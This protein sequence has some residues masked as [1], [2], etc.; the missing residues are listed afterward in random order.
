MT[1]GSCRPMLSSPTSKSPVNSDEGNSTDDSGI[2]SISDHQQKQQQQQQQ[3]QQQ[4][5]Q[6]Q[7]QLKS[8]K[9]RNIWKRELVISQPLVSKAGNNSKSVASVKD[10][11][12]AIETKFGAKISSST[13]AAAASTKNVPVY[14]HVTKKKS[15]V[16]GGGACGPGSKSAGLKRQEEHHHR[17]KCASLKRQQQQGEHANLAE[18]SRLINDTGALLSRNSNL[19][20]SLTISMKNPNS[21]EPGRTATI[22]IPTPKQV[23]KFS[24]AAAANKTTLSLMKDFALSSTPTENKT[25]SPKTDADKKPPSKAQDSAKED[26]SEEELPST[27]FQRHNPARKPTQPT[28]RSVRLAPKTVVK[29]ASK[30]DN[31]LTTEDESP[32]CSQSQKTTLL[33]LKTAKKGDIS[34]IINSLNKL[35]EEA[36]KDTAV[37]RRSLR[38]KALAARAANANKMTATVTAVAK[39]G[40][41]EVQTAAGKEA[42]SA[43]AGGNSKNSSL[44]TSQKQSNGEDA[45]ET[46]LANENEKHLDEISNSVP[47]SNDRGAK[48]KKKVSSTEKYLRTLTATNAGQKDIT[49]HIIKDEIDEEDED[50]DEDENE[51]VILDDLDS[52]MYL[53]AD[54]L[55]SCLYEQIG[56][57]GYDDV[58]NVNSH[59]Y[60]DLGRT[61]G[62]CKY[63]DLAGYSE[64]S[65]ANSSS[66]S[67]DPVG[68]GT[69]GSTHSYLALDGPEKTTTAAAEDSA[70]VMNR[71]DVAPLSR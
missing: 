24:A 70:S 32:G 29:L 68:G 37:L 43:A 39:E 19:R 47:S 58:G 26:S 52:T 31:L 40:G 63:I 34:K 14:S 56:S 22:V 33:G 10:T 35:D 59:K 65:K 51:I 67:Y 16:G 13:T 25:K 66:E 3:Q 64:I 30:F 23:R 41:E 9:R 57:E 69:T 6:D 50:E 1:V 54:Q 17:A 36:A 53:K 7:E 48:K 71:Y 46:K 8:S 62:S 4:M 61:D 12:K 21:K 11:V 44:M 27:T 55:G 20:A 2:D 45:A 49:E 38:R 18:L 42:T 5:L 15:H 60:L 28:R